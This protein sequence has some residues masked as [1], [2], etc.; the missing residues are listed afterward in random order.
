MVYP[1]GCIPFWTGLPDKN[2]IHANY[3]HPLQEW[4]RESGTRLR[5]SMA[6]EDRVFWALAYCYRDLSM[7][8]IWTLSGKIRSRNAINKIVSST[9]KMLATVL[10][11]HIRMPRDIEEFVTWCDVDVYNQTDMLVDYLTLFIDGTPIPIYEPTDREVKRIF[12]KFYKKQSCFTL[13]V[14]CAPNGRIVWRSQLYPGE[15]T[16]SGVY[17]EEGL[18]QMLGDYFKEWQCLVDGKQERLAVA[19]DKGFPAVKL[20]EQF[21]L[22]ITDSGRKAL[23]KMKKAFEKQQGAE[24]LSN[25]GKGKGQRGKG[26][27]CSAEAEE[28]HGFSRRNL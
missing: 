11:K 14:L 12:W 27:R 2:Y 4:L 28:D 15:A 26:K 7:R 20:P 17:K 25:K 21:Y 8:D 19:G 22:M 24:N 1:E 3:L 5:S 9:L 16:D 10:E 18:A 6:L 13:L 23:L